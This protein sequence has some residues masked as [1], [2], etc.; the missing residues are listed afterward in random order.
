MITPLGNTGETLRGVFA[1][2]SAITKFPE[3]FDPWRICPTTFGGHIPDIDLSLWFSQQGK[4]L[5]RHTKPTQLALIAMK[6]ALAETGLLDEEGKIP[7][8]FRKRTGINMGTGIGS[9]ELV[10]EMAL[11]M[12][13]VERALTHEARNQALSQLMRKH[14]ATALTILPDAPAFTC[15]MQFGTQG[16]LDCSTKACATGAGAIRRA[17]MEIL[18]GHADCMAAGGV[19]SWTRW[20]Q[21]PFNVYA[22]SG[23]LSKRNSDPQK[24]SRPFDQA[25]DGF[26]GSEG[27]GVLVLEELSHAQNRGARISAELVGYGETSDAKGATDPDVESQ[28]DVMRMALDMAGI[29]P[30]L[31]RAVKTHGTSTVAG[32]RGEMEAIRIVFGSRH[33][34]FLFAPKSMLGHTLGASGA[35]EAGIA[36]AVLQKGMIPPTINLKNPIPEALMCDVGHTHFPSCYANIPDRTVEA[37]IPYALCNAFGFGG[38]NACLVFKRYDG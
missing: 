31:V 16:P 1:G 21:M 26:V 37:N 11:D 29:H 3:E 32:D 15:S 14:V 24:A 17:A 33:D 30:S 5:G 10:A 7:I 36:V 13:A 18:L 19:E 20:D 23:A 2:K 25:H 22:R 12:N 34:L 27:A 9:S 4:R 35:I 6:E 38:Q 8:P 28:V